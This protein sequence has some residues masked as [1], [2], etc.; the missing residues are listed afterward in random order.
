[1]TFTVESNVPLPPPSGNDRKGGTG[2]PATK[3]P[4]GEMKVGD[5]FVTIEGDKARTAA[6]QYGK[7][8]GMRFITRKERGG[9]RIWRA[10]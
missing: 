4:F 2:R 5:S 9:I 10:A 8:N 6:A 1:M 3:Y 7:T